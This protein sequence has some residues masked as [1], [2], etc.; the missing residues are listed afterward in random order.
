MEILSLKPTLLGNIAGFR[1]TGIVQ[2]GTFAAL[3]QTALIREND[4]KDSSGDDIQIQ[5]QLKYNKPM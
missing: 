3:V 5:M 2:T 4:L 1:L